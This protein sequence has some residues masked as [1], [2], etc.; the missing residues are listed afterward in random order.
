TKDQIKEGCE[1]E[2]DQMKHGDL[3]FF[4]RHVGIACGEDSIVHA[5]LGGG[6]VR[7]NSIRPGGVDYRQDLDRDYRTT[8]RII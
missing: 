5:S 2:R 8:R 3:I 6:G 4:D 7:V 1:I